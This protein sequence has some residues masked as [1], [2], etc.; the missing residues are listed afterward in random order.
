MRSCNGKAPGH[1][2][3]G[4]LGYIKAVRK[5]LRPNG[6]HVDYAPRDYRDGA[7]VVPNFSREDHHDS[8]ASTG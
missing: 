2:V 6:G 7:V 8:F 1:F 3:S 4:F 5:P